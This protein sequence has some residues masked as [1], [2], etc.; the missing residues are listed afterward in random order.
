[1]ENK[2][3]G[4]N[5]IQLNGIIERN[6]VVFYIEDTEG[7]ILMVS[8]KDGSGFGLPGGK[9]DP[10]ENLI[11]ACIREIFEETGLDINNVDNL[12]K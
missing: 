9:V 7:D 11:E 4:V 8:R 6:S 1:M 10:N 3:A 2:I 12:K 5:R